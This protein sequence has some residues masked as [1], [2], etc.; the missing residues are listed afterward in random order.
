MN[1]NLTLTSR[2]LP[3]VWS[4][5]SLVELL[6]IPHGH[7][8]HTSRL[9]FKHVLICFRTNE[10]QANCISMEPN[11]HGMR[12]DNGPFMYNRP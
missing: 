2:Q 5:Q 1:L 11:L 7:P 4:L 6:L 8:T 3:I 9:C 10:Q 12:N